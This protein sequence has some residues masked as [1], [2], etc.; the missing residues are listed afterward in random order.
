MNTTH[1]SGFIHGPLNDLF[2]KDL[3]IKTG[4][5]TSLQTDFSVKGLPNFKTAYF[6]LPNLKISS[7]RID[8]LAIADTSI[9]NSI[10]LPENIN[11]LI[12]FKGQLKEFASTIAMSSSYGSAHIIATVDK[13][14]NFKGDISLTKFDLG[15]LLKNK[16]MYGPVSFTSEIKGHGLDKKTM[17]AG[18]KADVSQIFLNKYNYH[19]LLID[20]NITG[21]EFDGKINL[22]DE[23]AIFALDALINLDSNN[24]QYKFNLNVQGADL[25]KLNLTK[26]DVRIALIASADLRSDSAVAMKGKASVNGVTIVHLGKQYVIDSLLTASINQPD[27]S[28]VNINNA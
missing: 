11:L 1:A 13:N 9:P 25:Q 7:G 15:S 28:K 12:N 16:E 27:E 14:E 8:I 26:D 3:T 23:N 18:I 6:N 22:N 24:R 19:N 20:G 17:R 5:N 21:Q 2:G 10:K 4:V